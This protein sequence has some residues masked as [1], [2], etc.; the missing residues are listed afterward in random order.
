MNGDDALIGRMLGMRYQILEKIG[1]GGMA[2]VYRAMC[3]SL[4]RFV[5]VK[6]LKPEFKNDREI[7][8]KFKNESHA[9]AS[10]SHQ[11]IVSVFDVGEENGISYIVMEYIEGVTLK[12]YIKKKG[13]LPWQEACGFA[14][15]ICDAIEHAHRNNIIHNDIKPQNILI[16]PEKTAKVTDFGIARAVSDIN[17]DTVIMSRSAIGSVYYMS[18]EQDKG[19]FTDERSDMY[20][21]GIVFY[22][23]LTGRVPFTG[24]NHIEISLKKLDEEP[25]D[26]RIYNPDIP[27]RVAAAA[28][29][30]ISKEP[31]SRYQTA[32]ELAKE[33]SMTSHNN[34]NYYTGGENDNLS[35]TKKTPPIRTR[36]PVN[37]EEENMKKGRSSRRKKKKLKLTGRGMAALA[38]LSGILV[39][40]IAFGTY[41]FM[42]GGKKEFVVPDLMG[43][44]L[45]EAQ[46][47]I[48]DTEF[49]IIE[50]VST[51]ND[52][53]ET[54]IGR[55]ILQEPGA[56]KAVSKKDTK[57]T[58]T[59]SSG[60]EAKTGEIKV[61]DISGLTYEVA[62]QM[63]R[64]EKLDALRI[65]E[66]ND[67]IA[68]GYV[69]R[70]TPDKNEMV[71]EN[72]IVTVYVSSGKKVKVPSVEGMT[73][74]KA[75]EELKSY[76]LTAKVSTEES[77]ETEG[78]V[79]RQRPAA[80]EEVAKNSSVS[81]VVSS[82]AAKHTRAPEPTTRSTEN[83]M[84][85]QDVTPKP[86]ATVTPKTPTP[87]SKATDTPK[88]T[89][90]NSGET[91]PEPQVK[92][93][94]V[95]FP[96]TLGET[97]RV[98]IEAN[99]TEIYNSTHNKSEGGVRVPV[100]GTKDAEV[101]VYFDDSLVETR[102]ISF[103]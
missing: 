61:P 52:D 86:K 12:E 99:G 16:T 21:I 98:R 49:T 2:V 83:T 37:T 71:E 90:A 60:P 39:V 48:K 29:K 75:E 46:D 73:R 33:L 96:D 26:V 89:Q 13:I 32:E 3:H 82:G 57:I 72:T 94:T 81:I 10:L 69:I 15:Q 19:R 34:Y 68:E 53:D 56:N 74:E 20:S 40:A 36:R 11:N 24:A 64:N 18:P 9:V 43:L 54:K 59:I 1:S 55:I 80:N 28:L 35:D 70:Q 103:D 84:N 88:A 93:L 62:E 58:I 67:V 77:S 91:A 63:L 30:A 7:V 31:H 47:K 66:E 95:S 79:I 65:D 41:M 23:M 102:T 27:E 85:L 87:E 14:C 78:T 6:V 101:K 17:S 42:S 22:E 76:G 51:K 50:P 25:V 4:H 38:V 5:A 100:K 45:E 44:T 97:V 92:T 8:A